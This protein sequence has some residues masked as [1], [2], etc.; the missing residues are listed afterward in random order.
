[1]NDHPP[2]GQAF[3]SAL[4]TEHFVLQS[5]R[6]TT[7]SEAVGRSAVYLTCV[8]SAV[9]AFGFFAAAAH[10][11][12][13]VVATVLPALIILGIFTFV[14]LVETSVENVVFLRRMEA[15]RRYYAGLD[16]AAAAFFGFPD[17][18]DATT[19]LAS[20][21]MRAGVAEM[22]FTSASMIAAVTS[23]LSGVG[24]A[25]LLDTESVPLPAAVITG[26]GATIVT[27]GLHMLWMYRRG[28]PAMA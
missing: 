17:G 21:G 10:R 13:P 8:S 20:T 27:F 26:V 6:S 1:M 16:P 4:V 11:L 24:A 22:F 14:R 23:I 5:A 12:A 15:I 9:V 25:L 3:M 7:V 18:D 19:A 28:Q 2:P